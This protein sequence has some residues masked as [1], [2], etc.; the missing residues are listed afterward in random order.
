[1]PCEQP[2]RDEQTSAAPFL[3][4]G[5]VADEE[6]LL[7]TILNPDHVV[8]DEVIPA[9]VPL[10]DL[11]MKGF[12]VDRLVHVTPQFINNSVNRLLART[13]GGR[14]RYFVG[15]ARFSA[16]NVRGI[17]ESD[18]QIFVVIDTAL[19]CNTGHASVYLADPSMKGS[20]ARQFREKLLPL[21][22]HRMAVEMAFCV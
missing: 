8:D 9:A 21:L 20:K 13:S 10:R 18:E 3:S 7:R 15:V 19:S 11:Q 17:K 12:S 4:P 5:I 2:H 22:E 1:M 14:K 16:S 6:W